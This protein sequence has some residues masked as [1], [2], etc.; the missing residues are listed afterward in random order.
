MLYISEQQ[1]WLIII[2]IILS[3]QFIIYLR[4]KLF[5]WGIMKNSKNNAILIVYPACWYPGLLNYK[6]EIIQNKAQSRARSTQWNVCNHLHRHY[7]IILSNTVASFVD[8]RVCVSI[9][10]ISMARWFT[11]LQTNSAVIIRLNCHSGHDHKS[12]L[13]MMVVGGGTTAH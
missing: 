2:Y 9:E 8:P 10:P 7:C 6:I 5:H 3:N 1:F 4:N 12:K 11:V 13:I